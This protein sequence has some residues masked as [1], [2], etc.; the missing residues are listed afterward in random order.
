MRCRCIIH[1]GSLASERVSECYMRISL[2]ARCAL[3]VCAA[4]SLLA[5]CSNGG[6]PLAAPVPM[7]QSALQSSLVRS[8]PLRP[9]SGSGYEVLHDFYGSSGDGEGPHAG[10]VAFNGTFYGT[11]SAGGSADDGTVF[12]ISATGKERVIFS[13][14]GSDGSGPGS[15]LLH[16]RVNSTELPTAAAT[17]PIHWELSTALPRQARNAC[18]MPSKAVL[19]VTIHPTPA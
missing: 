17:G 14:N 18:S 5:D 19:T 1:S 15:V 11:T 10:L 3:V 2:W 6:S 9:A 12:T 13:F 16:T 8:I 4:V 7:P